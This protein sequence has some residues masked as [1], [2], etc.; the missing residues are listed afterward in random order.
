MFEYCAA[1]FRR[2][3][4]IIVR[5]GICLQCLCYNPAALLSWL[6]DTVVERRSVIGELAQS[7]A[8]PAAD[9]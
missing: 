9:G 4:D 8:R 1:I 5:T 7:Y 2:P 3:V 6:R